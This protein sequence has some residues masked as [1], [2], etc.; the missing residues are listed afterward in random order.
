MSFQVCFKKLF[1]RQTGAKLQLF[2]NHTA[3]MHQKVCFCKNKQ[4]ILI[5]HHQTKRSHLFYTI[6]A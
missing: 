4:F 1:C 6:F 5:F 2:K 3:F